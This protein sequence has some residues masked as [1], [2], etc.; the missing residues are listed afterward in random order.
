MSLTKNWVTK[1]VYLESIGNLFSRLII[2]EKKV[3][4][5][6]FQ[7]FWKLQILL[8]NVKFEAKS[9]WELI[10]VT[11]AIPK[12]GTIF[13]T[14]SAE[15]IYVFATLESRNRILVIFPVELSVHGAS[16][17]FKSYFCSETNFTAAL[18]LGNHSNSKPGLK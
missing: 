15:K 5:I 7:I 17:F 2:S 18:D 1:N 16:F 4:K 3:S 11:R 12:Y 10:D 13:F 14:T 9:F 8:E 6:I